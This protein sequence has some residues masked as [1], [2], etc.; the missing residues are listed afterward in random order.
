PCATE[1]VRTSSAT[2]CHQRMKRETNRES[3]KNRKQRDTHGHAERK[4]DKV[5]DEQRHGEIQIQRETKR[6]T[7]RKAPTERTADR[8]RHRETEREK[9]TLSDRDT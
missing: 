1:R 3:D 7:R 4:I 9:A 8:P 2:V 5:S 6:E